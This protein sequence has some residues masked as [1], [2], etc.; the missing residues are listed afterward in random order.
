[1]EPKGSLLHSQLPVTFPYPEPVRSGPCPHIPLPAG[2]PYIIIPSSPGCSKW[3][4]S[5]QISLPKPCVHLSSPPYVLHPPPISL[6]YIIYKLK[7]NGR[8]KFCHVCILMCE[9]YIMKVKMQIN[10]ICICHLSLVLETRFKEYITYRRSNSPM[11][12]ISFA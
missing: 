7:C 1:M 12:D 6:D 10:K 8:C 11:N 2:P 4:L 9:Q 3:S 5:P